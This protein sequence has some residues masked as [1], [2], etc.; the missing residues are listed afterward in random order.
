MDLNSFVL[1]TEKTPPLPEARQHAWNLVGRGK[2]TMDQKLQGHALAIQPILAGY[3][4]MEQPVL[5]QALTNYKATHKLMVD[6]R[7]EFTVYLDNCKDQCM[8]IEKEYDPTTNT[9]Y[10]AAVAQD[11]K[12]RQAAT[13]TADDARKK[14]TEAAAF[15]AHYINEYNAIIS[16]YRLAV[17]EIVQNAYNACLVARTPVEGTQTAINAAVAA[18]QATRP[19]AIVPFTRVL[20]THEEAKPIFEAI[21]AP[22][23]QLYAEAFNGAIAEM[24]SKF[25]LYAND[26][27]KPEQALTNQNQMF[28]KKVSEVAAQVEAESAAT[29]LF[30][31]AT[32]D[33]VSTMPAGMKPVT[34]ITCIE[35]PT[36]ISWEWEFT[37]IS[38]FL[39]NGQACKEKVRT[40]KGGALT[41]EQMAKALDAANVKVDGVKYAEI[42]K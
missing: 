29:N 13:K 42:S 32:V 41:T 30:T 36:V 3:E 40:K 31:Q 2:L 7:K 15:R 21:P 6:A 10:L 19:R 26:L 1:Y 4:K 33:V 39:A 12:L 5:A 22:S 17:Y 34:E 28:E 14:A 27:A 38:A 37:I 11:L 8:S 20:L 9:I 16:G 24:N 35:I 25:R 23:Q 18:I